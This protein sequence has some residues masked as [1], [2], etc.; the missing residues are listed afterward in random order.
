M[1][2]Y[3]KTYGCT[4]NASDADLMRCMLEADGIEVVRHADAA[5]VVVLNTC[6]VK[7]ATEQ[8]IVHA[9][10]TMAGMRVVVT[11]CMAGANADTIAR[12]APHASIVTQPNICHIADAVRQA[13]AGART[14]I[15][16]YA[17]TDRAA[18]LARMLGSNRTGPVAR[19]GIGDGCLS[20]CAFCE[21]RYARGPLNSFSAQQIIAAVRGSVAGGA[22][23][24][25]LAAQDAGAYG[26]ERR[27]NIVELM[28]AV[29][30]IEGDFKVRIGMLNP[31]HLGGYIKEFAS[32]LNHER[33]YKFV[34][35]PVQSGSDAVLH[36]M[37]RRYSVESFE[38]QVRVLRSEI[39][40]VAIATD[41]IVGYPT[42]SDEDFED[43]MALLSRMRFEMINISR[44][45]PRPHARASSLPQLPARLIKERSVRASRHARSIMAQNNSEFI[46]RDVEF[47]VT[48]ETRASLNGKS[49]S[50]RQVVLR[51]GACAAGASLGERLRGRVY[52]ASA[53]ALYARVV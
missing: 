43:T 47:R 18:L 35:L 40:G 33:F 34:H 45:A 5:D 25:Q 9:L 2:A 19:I 50:Y 46:G 13:S 48:E 44:F 6:T 38:E 32:A 4:L 31:E 12:A 10:G 51:K 39:E 23:D 29:S 16:G 14:V 49:D 15:D 3:I 11:G 17:H 20:A 30:E 21:T 37:R 36:D 1:R 7:R 53:Y 8:R 41:I 24:V 22:V 26:A 28:R 52:A 27:T 42:E